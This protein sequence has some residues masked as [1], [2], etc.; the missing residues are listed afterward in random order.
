MER[1]NELLKAINTYFSSDDGTSM[2]YY[3]TG[4]AAKAFA[5]IFQTGEL[6][7]GDA[8]DMLICKNDEALIIEHFEFDSYKNTRKGSNLK[9]QENF[10][11]KEMKNKINSELK[12]KDEVVVHDEIKNT[13]N[14]QQYYDIILILKSLNN[15]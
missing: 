6:L 12:T 9:I 13:S 7:I 11:E 3:G 14:L 8:P 5:N 15:S 1:A 10:I 4:A 2:R